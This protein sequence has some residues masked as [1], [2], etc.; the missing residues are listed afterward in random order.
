MAAGPKHPMGM[1]PDHSPTPS[2]SGKGLKGSKASKGIVLGGVAVVTLLLIGYCSAQE[3]DYDEVNAECVDLDSQQPDGSYTVVD[4]DYCND[5]DSHYHGSYGAYRWY[6]GG[7]R[8]GARI[9]RGTTVRPADVRIVS[10]QGTVIQR[11]G[12][13]FRGGS[14]S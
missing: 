2:A 12:F 9:M 14:G 6:Y 5:D 7:V 8:S 1:D 3:D 10:R 13:G 11:G 4:E